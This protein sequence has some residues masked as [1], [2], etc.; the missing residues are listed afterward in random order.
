MKEYN[1]YHN[2][3]YV[4]IETTELA[5]FISILFLKLHWNL[6]Y[7]N[8]FYVPNYIEIILKVKHYNENI[9]KLVHDFWVPVGL[10]LKE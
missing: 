3:I 1:T 9:F 4:F 10:I 6:I 7:S 5:K 8:I 2:W